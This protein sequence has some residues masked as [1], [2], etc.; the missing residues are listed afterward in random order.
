[1][2]DIP[3]PG[4]A[5]VLQ[6]NS[7]LDEQVSR[8][9]GLPQRMIDSVSLLMRSLPNHPHPAPDL[10]SSHS[11]TAQNSTPM[12]HFSAQG[13]SPAPSPVPIPSPFLAFL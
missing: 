6:A 7:A 1:M 5:G 8:L 12:A 10:T 3:G 11:Y 2:K 9:G 13:G 4:L